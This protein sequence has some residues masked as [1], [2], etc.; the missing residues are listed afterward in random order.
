MNNDPKWFTGIVENVDDPQEGGRIQVRINSVHSSDP[1]LL[2]TK[3][4]PWARVS[5]PTTSASTSE[6][7]G[8]SPTGLVV[9]SH[10][11]GISLDPMYQVLI[12]MFT[13]TTSDDETSSVH[14]LARG[15]E[16]TL[17]K[18]IGESLLSE[19][20]VSES[21]T[22]NEEKIDRS[23][24]KYPNSDVMVSRGGL[25]HEVDNSDGVRVTTSHPSKT[26]DTLDKE[27]NKTTKKTSIISLILKRSFEYI[28]GSKFVSIIEN[29]VKKIGGDNYT[30]TTG[31]DT[32]VSKNTLIK[33][34]DGLEFLTPEIRCSG[35]VRVAETIYVNEIR[36]KTLKA[37]N[38]SCSGSIQGIATYAKEAVKAAS[39]SPPVIPSPGAGA[40]NVSV[41]MKYTDNGGD[42]KF[43]V[44]SN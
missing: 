37:D 27:G 20:K 14:P 42:Y 33:T 4:L 10:I 21:T 23:K 19:I 6:G 12:A 9:G 7:V 40:G 44:E 29:S 16:S 38:I 34:N 30:N 15:L 26:Y 36:V 5:L 11:F 35:S 24:T 18:S 3:F 32:K 22:F 43:N 41:T 39:V 28:G 31:Q 17:S 13:W 25:E 1:V 2:P 8:E